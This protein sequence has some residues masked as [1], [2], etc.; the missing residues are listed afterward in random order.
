MRF[1]Y[2]ILETTKDEAEHRSSVFLFALFLCS[3]YL[4]FAVRQEEV[5]HRIFRV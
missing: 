5:F 3:D 1:C 2:P 4:L